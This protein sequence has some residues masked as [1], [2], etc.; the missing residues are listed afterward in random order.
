MGF[1][2]EKAYGKGKQT[3]KVAP[4]SK[5]T[6]SVAVKQNLRI[7]INGVTKA[8]VQLVHK[9][10]TAAIR[11]FC[12]C[13]KTFINGS[14]EDIK[15][16]YWATVDKEITSENVFL[17]ILETNTTKC[18]IL[19]YGTNPDGSRYNIFR[20]RENFGDSIKLFR[21][22]ASYT[23]YKDSKVESEILTITQNLGSVNIVCTSSSAFVSS[24]GGNFLIH[25]HVKVDDKMV[26]DGVRL[27]IVP[28]TVDEPQLT[29][30]KSEGT[31]PQNGNYTEFRI[32]PN[33][34][35]KIKYLKVRAKYRGTYSEEVVIRQIG[36]GTLLLRGIDFSCFNC[37][38]EDTAG[39]DF[40]IMAVAEKTNININGKLLDDFPVGWNMGPG[41]KSVEVRKYL[42]WSRDNQQTGVESV[43]V[44]W[45]NICE[46]LI[47][48]LINSNNLSIISVKIYGNWYRSKKTGMINV[49]LS[50]YIG[51]GM[52]KNGD[53]FIPNDK[54]T[55]VSKL[56]KTLICYA[57]GK[58]N[59]NPVEDGF[60]VR[61]CYSLI[62]IIEYDI[63]SKVAF[64]D[65]KS[66]STNSGRDQGMGASESELKP[67]SIVNEVIESGGEL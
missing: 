44:N 16:S 17:R 20:V 61:D 32:T 23:N 45:K 4:D 60:S 13:E 65:I 34:D 26:I 15:V 10:C 37:S 43:M 7:Q 25:Y 57:Q 18:L 36:K 63:R 14:G 54:T 22:Q 53:T 67:Q 40:D 58:D 6:A 38:W 19:S 12:T 50:N 3:I 42:K 48:S 29:F 46:K 9:S 28:G 5:N 31:D 56:D 24:R 49:N 33:P 47:N 2:L 41:N 27:E 35:D 64:V 11:V 1:T 55:M 66:N 51:T 62:A 39:R 21:V 52:I 30:S 8:V 59:S